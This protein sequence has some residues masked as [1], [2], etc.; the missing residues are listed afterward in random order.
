MNKIL[1]SFALDHQKMQVLL[2]S[3]ELLLHGI[4]DAD[5]VD[6]NLMQ[7]IIEYMVSHPDRIHHPAEEL[8]FA[9]MVE[10]D[11]DAAH[12]VKSLSSEH[13][14]LRESGNQF[15]GLVTTVVHDDMVPRKA[16]VE[17]GNTYIQLLRDHMSEE[18]M[19]VFPWADRSLARED[20]ERVASA[21]PDTPDPVFDAPQA[22]RFDGLTIAIGTRRLDVDGAQTG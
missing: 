12:V 16:I 20:W 15:L 22:G 7:E 5:D 13:L 3:L 6:F 1:K 10:R 4:E 14:Q 2:S 9:C 11:R 19:L 8:M 21:Y 17:S 18:E